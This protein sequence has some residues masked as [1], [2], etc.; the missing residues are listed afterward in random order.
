MHSRR[1]APDDRLL[2]ADLHGGGIIAPLECGCLGASVQS[3]AVGS[4]RETMVQSRLGDEH[5]GAVDASVVAERVDR[6]SLAGLRYKHVTVGIPEDGTHLS[7]AAGNLHDGPSRR[8]GVRVPDRRD[9]GAGRRKRELSDISLR[10]GYPTVSTP[11]LC[12]GSA[13]LL[14]L[15]APRSATTAAAFSNRRM[16]GNVAHV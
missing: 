13:A 2:V 12:L 9:T 8:E 11:S 10:Y 7:E 3:L 6:D 5:R 1:H 4:K 15:P 16:V 14:G